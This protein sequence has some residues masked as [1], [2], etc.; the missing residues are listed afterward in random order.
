MLQ[1]ALQ[2]VAFLHHAT[3][4]LSTGKVQF[5]KISTFQAG[6]AHIHPSHFGFK[7]IHIGQVTVDNPCTVKVSLAKFR[8]L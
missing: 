4:E 6:T 8:I 2:E 5:Q 7:K 1:S 3:D